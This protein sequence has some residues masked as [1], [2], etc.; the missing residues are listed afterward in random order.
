MLEI[1]AVTNRGIEQL[2]AQEMAQL[3]DIRIQQ[4]AYRRVHATYS[5]PPHRLFALRTVDDLFIQ[6]GEWQGISTH[7]SALASIEQ[8]ALELDLW[9]AQN[10]RQS[11]QP[12][13][14]APR[15]SVSANFVGRRNYTSEEIKVAV[16]K[17]VQSVTGWHYSEDDRQSDINLR[18]FIEH[19]HALIG[20]RLGNSPLYKRAYKQEHLP[21]SLKPTVAAAMLLL[22]GIKRGQSLLDPCCGAGTIL[23]EATVAG[24]RGVGGDQDVEAVAAAQRNATA[25]RVAIDVRAWDA[26][27]LPLPEASV[28]YVVSNLPWGRQ[29]ET[30]SALETF[31][32]RACAEIERVMV[33]QGRIVLLTSLPNLVHFATHTLEQEIPI[34]LFGQQ[35]VILVFGPAAEEFTLERP[36]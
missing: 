24:A 27:H 22:S 2:C 19:D 30:D 7:R 32:R 14:D 16:A 3:R 36:V 4:T 13:G 20:M 26:R 8:L 23:I 33:P 28:D 29:V 15:F 31:Y 25:A 17:S 35:P 12:M 10:M 9:Q 34:S 5:G 1:F 6:L 18:V 21:G 11:I